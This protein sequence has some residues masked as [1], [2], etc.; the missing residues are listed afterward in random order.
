METK[1][2]TTLTSVLNEKEV[3]QFN[4]AVTIWQTMPKDSMA[5]LKKMAVVGSALNTLYDKGIKKGLNKDD[6]VIIARKHFTG[7]KRRERSEY[8]KL[9]NNYEEIKTFVEKQK[10][11]SGNPTYLVNAWIRAGKEATATQEEVRQKAEGGLDAAGQP[12]AKDDSGAVT[13]VG[14]G[15]EVKIAG[16][17]KK[18]GI[19]VKTE[20]L[21]PAEVTVQL[22]CIVNQ[23]KTLFNKG[24]FTAEQL[25]EIETHLT[26][27]LQ[28]INDVKV[29]VKL[30]E[31]M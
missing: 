3:K 8:R 26:S 4:K 24:K 1:T 13:K 16:V 18:E 22:G 19:T 30:A 2:V 12:M 14:V 20:P 9:A 25:T 5:L 10:I 28:H 7:L 6:I 23:V 27:C 31:V 17:P 21:T 29:T 11:K 15:Q